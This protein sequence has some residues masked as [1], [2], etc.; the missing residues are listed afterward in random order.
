MKRQKIVDAE[1]VVI[2]GPS[3]RL[4]RRAIARK[5]LVVGFIG[6]LAVSAAARV[7]SEAEVH[8]ASPVQLR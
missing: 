4:L 1:F 8:A 3:R 5:W 2:M 6:L 7:A